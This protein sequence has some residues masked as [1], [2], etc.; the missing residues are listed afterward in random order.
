[1]TSGNNILRNASKATPNASEVATLRY[2]YDLSNIKPGTKGG[3]NEMDFILSIEDM[4]L[5]KKHAIAFSKPIIKV[6]NQKQ[7]T[8]SKRPQVREK[9]EKS[10]L[11]QSVE[12][13]AKGED[14]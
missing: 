1:M 9:R 8:N 12:K 14:R 7:L 2:E 6:H 4:E 10:E 5:A 13:I 3:R 11:I